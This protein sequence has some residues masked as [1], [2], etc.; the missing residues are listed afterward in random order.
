MRHPT[1][2]ISGDA[3]LGSGVEIG[4]Y[5][6]I[7]AGVEIGADSKIGAYTRIEGPTKIGERN[8]FY[9]S[10]SI[11]GPRSPPLR[12][13]LGLLSIRPLSCFLGP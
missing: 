4:P 11:G 13:P 6:I 10:A 9:G 3:T 5:A 8:T 2:I 7:G 1:A 12:S